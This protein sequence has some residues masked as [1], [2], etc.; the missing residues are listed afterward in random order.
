MAE[1]DLLKRL[2]ER[3]MYF[4]Q[5]V[6][7]IPAKFYFSNED[8]QTGFYGKESS[9]KVPE[10]KVQKTKKNK[11]QKLDP[12]QHK[13]VTKI[14]GEIAEK[15]ERERLEQ[16]NKNEAEMAQVD[17]EIDGDDEIEEVEPKIPIRP[18]SVEKIECS[19]SIE[20]LRVKLNS[21]IAS[22]RKKRKMVDNMN[23]G[24]PKK[25]ARKL[26]QEQKKAKW[27]AIKKAR[28]DM[29]KTKNGKSSGGTKKELYEPTAPPVLNSE[30]EV[31]F[32]KFE[33]TKSSEKKKKWVKTNQPRSNKDYTRLL[34]KAEMDVK[35][36]KELKEKDPE[37]AKQVEETQAW[38]KAMQKAQGA[39]IKDDPD[40]IKK[41][42]KK[43]KKLKI[44]SAKKWKDR[45]EQQEKVKKDKQE[46]RTKNIQSRKSQ[47][48]MKK[49]KRLQK[50]G[51]LL[52]G[53]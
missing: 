29:H 15:E 3:N 9:G 4:N 19:E 42:M 21:K 30:G 48:Q 36:M 16:S 14:Q 26:L 11:K 25:Q 12:A 51:K 13:S 41:T 2:T 23:N 27:E 28:A 8:K 43:Q 10:H 37:K 35:K 32:S 22:L 38:K 1:T 44:K 45:V 40:L 47:K 49:V 52:P 24:V 18:I 6:N 33:F 17:D 31:A 53:F 50:K 5:M 39:K 46:K 7:L 34:M 20:D